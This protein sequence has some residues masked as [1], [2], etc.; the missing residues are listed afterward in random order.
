MEPHLQ[1]PI[2][3]EPFFFDH[4]DAKRKSAKGTGMVM[5]TPY[6]YYETGRTTGSF[7][8]YMAHGRFLRALHLGNEQKLE[9]ATQ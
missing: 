5:R 1:R 2:D 7:C 9:V 6:H 3:C 4:D 8:K